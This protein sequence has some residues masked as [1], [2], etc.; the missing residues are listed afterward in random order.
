M[1][2]NKDGLNS[3][4]WNSLERPVKQ[5]ESRHDLLEKNVRVKF[6]D[7]VMDS[8]SKT[9][10]QPLP[11]R[12]VIF[13]RLERSQTQEATSSVNTS[14]SKPSYRGVPMLLGNTSG[15]PNRFR[16]LETI[17]LTEQLT[18]SLF[19]SQGYK[20]SSLSRN[21]GAKRSYESAVLSKCTGSPHRKNKILPHMILPR[22]S[23][24]LR[25]QPMQMN[26]CLTK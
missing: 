4:K 18:D 3:S 10:K 13:G 26:Y 17:G 24:R 15:V 25:F 22:F 6:T 5:T 20:F 23:K 14:R 21:P 12:E 11:P 16:R 1:R 9:S 7:T 19:L 2:A 8:S